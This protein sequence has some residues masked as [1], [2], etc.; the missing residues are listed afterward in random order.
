MNI[1]FFFVMTDDPQHYLH[2]CSLV[3][4]AKKAMPKHDVVQLTDSKT[5]GVL[6]CDCVVRVS[7]NEPLLAQR[8]GHY[9]LNGEWLFLDTDV[10]IKNDVA[11]I[12]DDKNF[13]VA[14]CDRN[15]PN[16]E[17]E[18]QRLSLSMP[19]NTGVVFSRSAQFWRDVKRVWL[20]YP[21]EVQANWM[22]EQ[23]A[24]YDVVRTGH[25]KVKILPG[26][27]YNY[28]P[29]HDADAPIT[30]ALLHYKGNRKAWLSD[31]ATQVM[32]R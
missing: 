31:H 21:Q 5:P 19:F 2:A 20:K 6:G 13:D 10:S 17:E 27:F 15:W 16:L 4:E 23:R 7:S 30:A 3:V 18:S 12:F 1:G 24:V 9:A 28:P 11:G 22:S 29:S 14:L 8:L 25:Y 32:S 26:E